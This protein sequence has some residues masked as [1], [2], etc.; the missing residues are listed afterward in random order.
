MRLLARIHALLRRCPPRVELLEIESLAIDRA[1]RRVTVLG[2][3]IELSAKEFALL[4]KLASDP[5]RVFTREQLLRDVWGFRT[6]VPTRTLE[7]H[8]SRV[9]R[10]IAAAGLPGW[11]VNVWGVGYKLRH[12]PG[13]PVLPLANGELMPTRPPN[14]GGDT[15]APEVAPS[16]APAMIG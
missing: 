5:D 13:G 11:I 14:G 7:S 8:A 9:R 1:A 12:L 10:K 16:A 4:V 3:E 6:Y 15:S 2:Q